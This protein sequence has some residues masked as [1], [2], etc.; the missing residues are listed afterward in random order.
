MRR[1]LVSSGAVMHSGA[2]ADAGERPD[3]KKVAIRA[4]ALNRELFF[5]KAKYFT[6]LAYKSQKVG[7]RYEVKKV[8]SAAGI[9]QR[10]AFYAQPY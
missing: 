7:S 8:F 5:A 6:Y 3:S 9:G 2:R 4:E 1:E 10:L